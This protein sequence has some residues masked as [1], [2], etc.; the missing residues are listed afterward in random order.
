MGERVEIIAAGSGDDGRNWKS[1][2]GSVQRILRRMPGIR[3]P[4]STVRGQY[5]PAPDSASTQGHGTQRL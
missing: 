5:F 1:N 3:A 2:R 4:Q